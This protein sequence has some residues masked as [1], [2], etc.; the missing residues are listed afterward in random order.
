MSTVSAQP[1]IKKEKQVDQNEAFLEKDAEPVKRS[2]QEK[3]EG[4]TW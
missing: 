2:P 1:S 4:K 3:Q